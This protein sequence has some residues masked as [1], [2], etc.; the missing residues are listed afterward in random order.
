MSEVVLNSR[1][2]TRLFFSI[3]EGSAKPVVVFVHNMYGSYRSFHRHVKM[4]NEMGYSTVAFDLVHASI[5]KEAPKPVLVASPLAFM[6]VKWTEQITDVLDSIPG[7]KIVFS[8]SGPS[9]SALISVSSR[10]DIEK[11]ICEGGPFREFWACTYR[12]FTLEKKIT[13]PIKRWFWTTGACLL[14]GPFAFRHLT[15]ALGIW[16]PKLPL[17]SIRGAEDLIVFPQNIQNV[18]ENQNHINLQIFLIEKGQHLDGLKNFPEEYKKAISSFL[19]G[20]I[21]I[22]YA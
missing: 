22:P 11:C 9:I 5:N 3:V 16:N 6:Y 15:E 10:K 13:N 7:Q 17:L 4:F 20:K 2:G 19:N 8:F 12:M 21:S 14:W 1:K 18:F